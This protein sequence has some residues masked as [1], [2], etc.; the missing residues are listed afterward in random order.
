MRS[1]SGL[2]TEIRPSQ[3]A[4]AMSP[5]MQ[6]A[7]AQLL[8]EA[9]YQQVSCALD[10]CGV[11]HL[12]LKG[13]HLGWTVYSDP[14]E[15]PYGDLDVLVRAEQFDDAVTALTAGGFAPEGA[16]EGRSATWAAGY[17]KKHVSPHGWLVE[18]H[19]ELAPHGQYFIDYAGLFSRAE[20]FRFG[21]LPARGLAT[22]DLLLHLVVHAGKT[23]ASFA[24][25]RFSEAA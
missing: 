12:L 25:G 5:A 21:P 14:A 15:R 6:L 7:G 8:A 18:L 16:L 20:A 9:A 24:P 13:P 2:P 3:A 22:E 11:D 23:A 17:N 10:S 4:D 19:R 1:G